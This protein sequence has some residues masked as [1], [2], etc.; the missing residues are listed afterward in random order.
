MKK[1]MLSLVLIFLLPLSTFR[2][3]SYYEDINVNTITD[4]NSIVIVSQE[5][6]SEDGNML[7]PTGAILGV[8][9][10]EEIMF[11]Y[12][13]FVQSDLDMDYRINDIKINDDLVS[14][15]LEDLFNFE[16]DSQVVEY[17][18]VQTKLLEE[19][20]DG[21]FVEVTVTLS[22]EFPTEAQFSLVAGQELSFG[23]TFEGVENQS[24]Q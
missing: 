18:T 12:T 6:K 23:I 5:M 1:L 19:G 20:H 2:V 3:Y 10:V 9:D 22:M 7:V 15:D 21:F 14:T 11:N 8:G 16:F 24:I 4:G 13:I 17:T